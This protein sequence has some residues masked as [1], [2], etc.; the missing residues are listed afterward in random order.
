MAMFTVCLGALAGPKSVMDATIN[1]L[2]KQVRG[3]KPVTVG[4]FPGVLDYTKYPP[5]VQ[6]MLGRVLGARGL[7]TEGRH[8]FRNWDGIRAWA[9]EVN[10]LLG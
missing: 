4:C 5:P 10:G 3:L 7:P 6:F 8:D 2:L 1:P 9:D